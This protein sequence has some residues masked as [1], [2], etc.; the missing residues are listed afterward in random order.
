MKKMICLILLISYTLFAQSTPNQKPDYHLKLTLE[1]NQLLIKNGKE[2]TA[3]SKNPLE[4]LFFDKSVETYSSSY[5]SLK[6]NGNQISAFGKVVV[7]EKLTFHF[8]DYWTILSNG[9]QLEREVSVEGDM[10]AGFASRIMLNASS[11]YK[12]NQT[13]LFVPGMIYGGAEFLS[14]AAI[15]GVENYKNGNANIFIR[16]DRMPAPVFGVYF[17]NGNSISLLNPAPNGQTTREESHN[18]IPVPL[19]DERFQFGSIGVLIEKNK[20]SLGYCFPGNEGD[21][22]YQGNVYPG[23]QLKQWRRRFHPV[24]NGFKHT[25]TVRILLDKDDSFPQFYTNVW[26]KSYDI[27]NPNVNPHDISVV[28]QSVLS[29]LA[30]QVEIHDDWCGL[31]NWADAPKMGVKITDRKAVMGFTGKNLES[32][33]FLLRS[34]DEDWNKNSKEYREKAINI[35]NSFLKIKMDPPVSSGFNLDTGAPEIA[36]PHE[37]RI[38]LRSLGDGFKSLAHTYLYEQK[39]GIE[40]DNWLKWMKSFADWLLT[41]QKKDGGFPRAWLPETG[42]IVEESSLSS[43]NAV[44]FL[45]LLYEITKEKKYLKSAIKAAD[46]SW[47]YSQKRGKFIGGTI[48]NPNVLDKEAATI[49][50]EAY[51]I[52]YKQTSND[53]WLKRAKMAANFA[54]TWVYIWNVP[55]PIDESN[56]VLQWKKGNST[57]GL[58]LI[59]TGHSLVDMYMS[60]DADEFAELFK[61]TG[62][63]HYLEVA[64]ILLHNTKS[65]T[66]IPNRIYDLRDI[67]WQQEHWSLSPP[68]GFALHRGWLPWVSTSQ[69]NG[70]YGIE[71][72]GDEKIRQLLLY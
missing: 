61:L 42:E 52:L 72:I 3:I 46:V 8:F 54:E 59:S 50:L 39:K 4:I 68:R 65:M 28:K 69:L 40:H 24:K 14:S 16:E 64:R 48:D 47:E 57:I 33:R 30:S 10:D 41:Q 66:A 70:I 18:L 25:Y 67:G 19:T 22:T 45:T 9:L 1:K 5:D 44:P 7:N 58:Q 11:E 63:D 62:D 6:E 35:I 31:P 43:Y 20:L 53:K 55:M 12:Q 36:L 71:D 49:S 56:R 29:A 34:A 13:Q 21:I 26:R 60:F 51:L 32:A 27:L 15:G 38:Y 17:K 37:K 2:I 23:G